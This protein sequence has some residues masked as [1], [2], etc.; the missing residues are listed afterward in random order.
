MIFCFSANGNSRWVAERLAEATH[1][2]LFNMVECLRNPSD[3]PVRLLPDASCVGLVFPVH[4]WRAPSVVFQFLFRFTFPENVYRYAV[5]TCGDDAGKTMNH[6]SGHFRLDAAWSV[7]MPN[8]YIPMFNLD[9]AA[10]AR[11]KVEEARL[12]MPSLAADI[13]A[14]RRV[15]KV[16]EGAAPRL[17][18]YLIHPLFTRFVVSPRGFHA[19]EGCVSCG[20]CVKVCPM[21]NIHLVKGR[22]EWGSVCIH[23]MAC[24]HGCPQ[25]VIQFRNKTQHRGRYRM[26]F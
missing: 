11:R 26:E 22:P 24:V 1:D 15:W 4:A 21:E 9:D 23:C 18:T 16:H 25:E 6:L 8:T 7:T 10:L 14:G 2:R 17:K 13:L 19:D 5:C 12:S 3:F 20:T